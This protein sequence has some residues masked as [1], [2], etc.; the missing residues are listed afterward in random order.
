MAP[1]QNSRLDLGIV[2]RIVPGEE[3]N[4][5][6]VQGPEPRGRVG[7]ALAHDRRDQT[8]EEPDPESTREGRAV[9][10]LAG[11]TGADGNVRVGGKNRIEQGGE[12]CRVVLAVGVEL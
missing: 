1:R 10:T 3:A 6:P 9:V 11:E 12:P 5:A 7:D 2:V 4:P 8:G